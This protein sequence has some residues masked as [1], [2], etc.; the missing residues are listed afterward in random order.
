MPTKFLYPL[1]IL[2]MLLNGSCKK[3]LETKSDETLSKPATLNDLQLILDNPDLNKGMNLTNVGTDEY[4]ITYSDWLSLDEIKQKG[5]TWHSELDDLID[6]A[7]QYKTVFHANTALY[8][9]DLILTKES[10]EKRNTI[11]GISLFFR[12]HS[13]YQLVQLYSP[14]YDEKTASKDL[15]IPL[16]L[17]ADFNQNSSRSTVQQTYD[18]I[19][20]DIRDALVL[21]PNISLIKTRP[22]KGACY[23]LLARTYLQMGNYEK[24]LDASD[25]CLKIYTTLLDYNSLSPASPYPIPTFSSNPEIIFYSGNGDPLNAEDSRVKI[26][27]NLYNS[28]NNDDLR[29]TI[30]F[31]DNGDGT[32]GFKGN[33]SG[34]YDLFTGLAL[35]EIYLIRA[36][37]FARSGKLNESLQDLN[38]LLSQRWI[39]GTFIPFTASNSDQALSLILNERKKELIF[40]SIRWCDLKRLNKESNFQVTIKRDLD[41]QLF[42][43]PP[44][45]LRYQLLIPKDIIKLTNLI[46]NPR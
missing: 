6:W 44:N 43:L 14:Q 24:A 13:F 10:Q 27:S 20:K 39:S 45:D 4:Y 30:L 41:N 46:Q 40:R 23:A 21:L 31:K 12:A 5:Y 34:G 36:E 11:K 37:C 9:L 42:N 22:D 33:Y 18:Q 25:S 38:T 29:K 26:D 15:G 28:F 32:F 8:N 1:L 7:V 3:Y 17:T 16:R 19:I 2:F 35:D